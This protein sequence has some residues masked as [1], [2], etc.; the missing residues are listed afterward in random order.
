VRVYDF[1][2]LDNP[3]RNSAVDEARAIVADAGVPADWHDCSHLDACAPEPGDLII[4]VI[5][6]T[7]Q[8]AAGW[9]RA[10]G[11]SV[12]DPAALEERSRPSTSI[13][14]RT[15]RGT[16]ERTWR[17]CWDARSRTRSVT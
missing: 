13:G 11:F 6:E 14:S 15:R 17:F 12:V 2:S 3:L 16:Q 5:R 7:G 9:H 8:T 10:L 1:S 4:R